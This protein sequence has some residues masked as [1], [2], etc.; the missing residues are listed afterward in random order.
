V[1]LHNEP[2]EMPPLDAILEGD[3]EVLCFPPTTK[4]HRP[5]VEVLCFT[6]FSAHEPEKFSS[7]EETSDSSKPSSPARSTD[8][9]YVHISAAIPWE[10]SE[11]LD[12]AGGGSVDRRPLGPRGKLLLRVLRVT[13]VL[14][15][16]TW[17]TLPLVAGATWRTSILLV[18]AHG[19]MEE[20]EL[21]ERNNG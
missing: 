19:Q 21:G 8:R 20:K 3:V 6:L 16:R 5:D 10:S 18:L 17:F 15:G 13:E 11:S 9:M 14:R 7:S 2:L 4:L 1:V 12:D